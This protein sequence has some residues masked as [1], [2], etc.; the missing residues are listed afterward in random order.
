MGNEVLARPDTIRVERTIFREMLKKALAENR[1]TIHF[2]LNGDVDAV[3]FLDMMRKE[4]I[5][6]YYTLSNNPYDPQSIRADRNN[7]PCVKD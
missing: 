5:C 2:R 4:P 1:L 6:S 3:D 7:K